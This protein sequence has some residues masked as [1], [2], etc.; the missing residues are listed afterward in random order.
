[1][2]QRGSVV[3]FETSKPALFTRNPKPGPKVGIVV[4]WSVLS[5]DTYTEWEVEVDSGNV[6]NSGETPCSYEHAPYSAERYYVKLEDLTVLCDM[7][8]S[9]DVPARLNN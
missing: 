9:L 8:D 3:A 6:A 1:M 4:A 2:V 7:R 5:D